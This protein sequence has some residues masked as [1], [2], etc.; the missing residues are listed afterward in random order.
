MLLYITLYVETKDG[1]CAIPIPLLAS[2]LHLHYLLFLLGLL[3]LTLLT[4]NA[5]R[6]I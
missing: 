5:C 3:K 1:V 2:F 4:R 6:D